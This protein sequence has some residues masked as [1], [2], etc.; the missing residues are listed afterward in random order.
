[1]GDLSDYYQLGQIVG[2]QMVE[3]SAAE[4]AQLLGISRD[5][6][7]KVMTAYEKGSKNSSAK[8]NLAAVPV[9]VKWTEKH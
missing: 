4:T 8:H 1:M 7:S 9:C 6:V 2:A 5:T 3:A